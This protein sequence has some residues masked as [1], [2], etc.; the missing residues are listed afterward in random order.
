[1]TEFFKPLSADRKQ[2]IWREW[3]KGSGSVKEL[4]DRRNVVGAGRFSG[5]GEVL[6]RRRQEEEEEEEVRLSGLC[7]WACVCVRR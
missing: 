6:E 5:I 2:E 1:M 3:D 4:L 7:V